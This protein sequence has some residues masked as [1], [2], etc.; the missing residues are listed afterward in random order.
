MITIVAAGVEIASEDLEAEAAD[1]V[2]DEAQ[3]EVEANYEAD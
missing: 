3:E 1:S 2:E